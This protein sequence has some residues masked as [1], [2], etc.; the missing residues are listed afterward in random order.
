MKKIEKR[1]EKVHQLIKAISAN[2]DRLIETAVKDAGFTLRECRIEVDMNLDNLRGFD[3]MV[4]VFSERRPICRPDQEVALLLP[5]NGS[6]WLN[7][8]ILSIF[9][10]GN[11]VRVKF[12]TR[13]SEISRFTESL[14]KPIF[15]DDICFEYSNGRQFLEAAITNPDIPAICL[16]GSDDHALGYQNSVKKFGKKFIFEGPGK[17]PFIV[18]SGADLEAA[19]KELS[20]SKYIYAGQTCTAP[21]RVYVHE[22]L[23]DLFVE[24]LVE[25]SREVKTGDPADP[26]TQMGPVASARAIA[27]IKAQLKDA[28][29]KGA[30][31]VLGGRI[32]GH[33]VYPTIVADATH[34]MLG[35]REETFGPVSYICS[36]Q[37]KD[38]ALRL[39][40]DNRYGLRASVYGDD[41]AANFGNELVGE[42]YCHPVDKMVYGLFGTVGVN[43]GRSESWKG[44]FV[45][46][47]VG[48]YGYSG[49]IWETIDEKFTLKQ[50]PKLL[51]LETSQK[52][53]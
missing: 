11:R 27:N 19:A 23:H 18:L 25:L 36:F 29:D 24:R 37:N 49:W 7:T 1:I 6:A 10:V 35:V 22:S 15:G 3:E 39:A 5:Y 12:A 45:S 17:D 31:V 4:A 40:R 53:S 34:D 16:F 8:A 2:R 52:T 28:V 42:P 9:L 48:G 50:G 13:G 38:V 41:K 51:S 20:F 30:R 46:K 32:D 47:P 44:A 21:E 43:Q 14:Y 33:M 26:D